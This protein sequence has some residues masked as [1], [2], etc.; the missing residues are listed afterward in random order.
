MH[1]RTRGIAIAVACLS[2]VCTAVWPRN[3]SEMDPTS[4]PTKNMRLDFDSVAAT[5]PPV[6]SGS[7][8]DSGFPEANGLDSILK[9]GVAA[10]QNGDRDNARKLLSQASAI[11][12]QCEDAWMWLASISDYPEE[13][14]AFLDRVLSI[15]PENSRAIEWR[16]ATRSLLAKNFVQRAVA[17]REQGSDDLAARCVDQAIQFDGDFAPAWFVRAAMTTDDNQKIEFLDRVLE[18]EPDH[19]GAKSAV[20][21]IYAARSQAAFEE[22]KQAAMTGDQAKALEI[23]DAYLKD[24]PESVE[25]WTLKSHLSPGVE[26]KIE[27]LEKALEIDPENAAARSGLAFLALTF[28][29]TKEA[30]ATEMTPVVATQHD[31]TES[32]ELHA[33]S[34]TIP[35]ETFDS[36]E[37]FAAQPTEESVEVAAKEETYEFSPQTHD[38]DAEETHYEDLSAKSDEFV[39]VE[40][41]R[42]VAKLFTPIHVSVDTENETVESLSPFESK[43]SDNVPVETQTE[44]VSAPSFDEEMPDQ[45]FSV[46]PA[47]TESVQA[48]GSTCPFCGSTNVPQAFDCGTCNARLTLSDIEAL[49]TERSVNRDFLQAAVTKMEG[50]WN[51]REF[52]ETEMTALGLG[53]LNLGNTESGLR[54][55][56]EASRLD[57]NNVIL[58]G[59]VN[60]LAI[61]MDEIRRQNEVYETRLTGKRI[62]VVDDSPT[63]R[64]LIAG[65]LEKSGHVV[66]CASDGVE[67]LEQLEQELPDLV[68]L[69]ITMP[70]MDGY[71]V[72]KQI[73]SNPQAKDLPVVM[74]SGKDGFFDK[75]R[76]RMAGST[77]Y[78]T[79]PFGP[80]TLM[81]ALETYLL[82]EA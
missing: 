72:C 45:S 67:A 9:K 71:E 41:Q 3:P 16:Q 68:L 12:P 23:L 21:A 29:A 47:V 15:N 76:G 63:V 28:G 17:A 62:L 14:L 40:Q 18:L 44:E 34:Y 35:A 6:I 77:G 37:S 46:E 38:D 57:A 52:N 25:A 10:A 74:I 58:A 48:D 54:Y 39:E 20:A 75:V 79:K 43:V 55:L 32:D 65:K 78:V 61:R 1:A 26:Q 27:A 8:E 82:P 30:T 4:R 81:K 36:E 59:Q 42:S 66:V 69:D 60:V 7:F 51:L 22:A 53:H 73:R 50:E 5:L 33:E 70:R 19:D 49:L 2:D 64:K 56:Q 31:E 11:D 13:L 80:E 24:V